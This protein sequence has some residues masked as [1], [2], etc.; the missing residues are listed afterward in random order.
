[1]LGKS[2]RN[3]ERE[4]TADELFP[5]LIL[6]A[7]FLGVTTMLFWMITP[8]VQTGAMMND[9]SMDWSEVGIFGAAYYDPD[10]FEVTNASIKSSFTGNPSET[11]TSATPHRHDIETWVIRDNVY[12]GNILGSE[13][14][15]RYKDCFIFKMDLETFIIAHKTKYAIIPF[16]TVIE[17]ANYKD[18]SSQVDFSLNADYSLFINTG[19]G[20]LISD[21]VW[22]NEFNMSIGW[23]LNLSASTSASPWGLVGQ[24]LTFS[25]P[26]VSP[27]VNMLIGI[28][29]YMTLGFLVVAVI[30]RFFPTIAGV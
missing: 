13:I 23:S 12:Y 9:P 6:I 16:E 14:S 2:K 27:M 30:S 22:M 4:E 7:T 10:P 1:M 25:I 21:G 11:F 15:S 17:K 29:I 3:L 5:K 20:M 8:I 19:P 18:N 24:I 26:N 28:P